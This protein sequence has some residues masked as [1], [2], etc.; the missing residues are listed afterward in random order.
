MRSD[1]AI[2]GA[3]PAGSALAGVLAGMGIDCLLVD[4][5]T[6]RPRLPIGDTLSGNASPWLDQLGAWSALDT[7]IR[8]NGFVSAWSGSEAVVHTGL[9]NPF[10]PGWHLD[11]IGFEARLLDLARTRGAQYLAPAPVR[12]VTGQGQGL[13]IMGDRGLLA[14]A[15]F[16]ID[17]TGSSALVS[18][19]MGA[20]RRSED[21]LVFLISRS[22]AAE[23][24][25]GM[26][27]IE[28]TPQGWWYASPLPNGR[29][30]FALSTD[31]AELVGQ[32]PPTWM[33]EQL[34]S[35]C[36]IGGLAKPLSSNPVVTGAG[37]AVGQVEPICGRN[38]VAVG[39][40]AR[41]VDP[42]QG[43]GILFAL[44]DAAQGSSAIVAALNGDRSALNEWEAGRKFETARDRKKRAAY[45]EL[46]AR[47]FGTA[48]WDRRLEAVPNELIHP[49][50]VSILY[51]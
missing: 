26:L 35:T 40:A 24:L 21:E 45:Y 17:A 16:V 36:H 2:I 3:G 5:H 18:R 41:T 31:R 49:Q 10:G 9:N 34:K 51:R 43:Q 37:L 39:D 22:F 47:Q 32:D 42:L 44:A 11:R 28:S 38:W 12:Q 29:A 8:S 20:R 46:G 7:S 13:E 19:A 48:F 50:S 14:T 4:R 1:V 33:L 15:R 25:E 30:V 23:P 27:H 6:N